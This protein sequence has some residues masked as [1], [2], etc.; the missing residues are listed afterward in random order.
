[1]AS[2]FWW[3]DRRVDFLRQGR[4]AGYSFTEIAKQLGTTRSAVAGKLQRL[5]LARPLSEIKRRRLVV[6]RAIMRK[7]AAKLRAEI[8]AAEAKEAEKKKAELVN[9]PV[10]SGKPY[11]GKGILFIN[12]RHD[13]C[14]YPLWG[15]DQKTGKVCAQPVD[16]ESRYCGFH[17][18][19]CQRSIDQVRNRKFKGRVLEAAE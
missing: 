18:R 19:I 3:T 9:P 14:H 1:M 10:Q 11:K 17:R 16:G 5:G 12:A 7:K 6:M 2:E 8:R 15:D 4:T 13:Q